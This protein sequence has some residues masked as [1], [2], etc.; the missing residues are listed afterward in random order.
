MF[1]AAIN[2]NK[3]SITNPDNEWITSGSV[4]ANFIRVTLSS[5]WKGLTKT[6]VFQTSHALIPILLEGDEL[7]YEVPIP[8]ECMVFVNDTINVGLMGTRDDDTQT[9]E[10]EQKVLPTVWSQIPEK[11]RQGVIVGDPIEATPT[12]DAYQALL[13]AIKDLIGNGTGGG[14][15]SGETGTFFHD[16]LENRELPDQHP[17]ESITGLLSAIE[18]M[19]DSEIDSIMKG[20]D[21]NGSDE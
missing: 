3:L 11:V 15:G 19:S 10:D 4:N 1:L 5:D 20:D 6:I 7:E 2:D 9:T 18:P 8:W 12:Y 17:I 13:K 16:K 14:G 21:Q